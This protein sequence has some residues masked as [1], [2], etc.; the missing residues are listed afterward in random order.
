[1]DMPT[2][3]I[4]WP[5]LEPVTNRTEHAQ[6]PGMLTSAFGEDFVKQY[7][8]ISQAKRRRQHQSRFLVLL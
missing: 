7:M 4:G 5:P 3:Q 2:S 1:M 6:I 8:D